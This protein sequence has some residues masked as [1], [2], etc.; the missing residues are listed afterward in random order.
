[1]FS[2]QYSRTSY[3]NGWAL[4]WDTY[5]H[6]YIE[7]LCTVDSG[8]WKNMHALISYTFLHVLLLQVGADQ[9]V[10]TAMLLHL[11]IPNQWI[12]GTFWSIIQ[13]SNWR[14]WF[15]KNLTRPSELVNQIISLFFKYSTGGKNLSTQSRDKAVLINFVIVMFRDKKYSFGN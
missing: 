10:L 9:Y 5:L 2:L 1:M 8:I 11:I 4:S 15:M 12:T 7:E 14:R 6:L 13:L 3:F